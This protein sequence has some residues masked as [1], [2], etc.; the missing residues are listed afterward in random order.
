MKSTN[1]F[2]HYIRHYTGSGK[3][4]HVHGSLLVSS[5]I[6]ETELHVMQILKLVVTFGR[7]AGKSDFQLPILFQ[8]CKQYWPGSGFTYAKHRSCCCF[9]FFSFFL[10]R[11]GTY[12]SFKVYI[13]ECGEPNHTCRPSPRVHAYL[14]R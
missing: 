9:F 1:P 8:T 4:T 2:Q 13:Q 6:L 5:I 10:E 7:Q 14:A 3:K 12:L 11:Q